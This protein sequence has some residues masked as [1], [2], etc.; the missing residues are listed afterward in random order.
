MNPLVQHLG[1]MLI[2]SVWEDGLIWCLLQ[3]ALLALARKSSQSRY[4]ASCLA[5][6]A[7]AVLPWLT[8]DAADISARL[9]ARPVVLAASGAIHPSLPEAVSALP[10]R[11]NQAFEQMPVPFVQSSDGAVPF[12]RWLPWL[13]ALWGAGVVLASL[14]LGVAW[15]RAR[16]LI[17]QPLPVLD[18]AWQERLGRLAQRAGVDRIVQL[19]ESAAVA[20]P[21]VAGWLKP[22][23]LLP[24]GVLT[25]L[26]VEQVEA[27][28]LHE[29][30]HIS[31]HDYLANLLQSIVESLFFYHPA[32]W[33][34]SRRIR[35][36]RELACDD[37]TVKWCQ[38]RHTYAE[39]LAGFEELRHQPPLLAATGE[40]DLLARIRRIL[41]E[42]SPARRGAPILG[43]AGLCG[44]G[45]YLAS[46]LLAPAI[47]QGALTA[48]ERITRIEALQPPAPLED[49]S[50][51]SESV[52]VAGTLNTEDGA[53]LPP[54]LIGGGSTL[55]QSEAVI[56]SWRVG[57]SS[58]GGIEI[59]P[60]ERTFYAVT[61]SG[62]IGIGIWAEGYAPLRHVGVD[63]KGKLALVLRR[64]FLARVQVVA[65]DG[66]L[67]PGAR[68][69]AVSSRAGEPFDLSMPPAHTDAAGGAS[70]GHVEAASEIHLTIT[71]P[72]WQM[73][74]RVVT[75]WEDQAPLV[76]RLEPAR[77]TAGQIIDAAS[78][79]PVAQA[80]IR[81]AAWR[82]E[83][84]GDHTYD[85][86][87]AQVL[88]HS[89]REGRFVLDGLAENSSCSIYIIAK[90]YATASFPIHYG[91]R[92]RIC[93]L[94]RG[95]RL[96]G[97]ILD[98]AGRLRKA[99]QPTQILCL[100]AISATPFFSYGQRQEQALASPGAE[101][102]FAF[103]DLPAG[104]IELILPGATGRRFELFLKKNVENYVIDLAAPVAP[105]KSPDTRPL[106]KVEITLRTPGGIAPAGA[107]EGTYIE[108][109][110]RGDYQVRKAVPLVDGKAAV[111]IPA[112]CQ[113]TLRA[114]R[115]IG[116]WFAPALIEVPAG[117]GT[118]TRTLDALPAGVIHGKVLLPPGLKSRYVTVTPVMLAAPAGM[119][120]DALAGA[121]GAALS[122]A[123]DY[124][125]PALPFGGTYAVLVNAAPAYFVGGPIGVDAGHPLAVVDMALP[126][127]QGALRGRLVDEENRPMVYR[128]VMLCYR[129]TEN[130]GF[131]SS[132]ATTDSEGR[133][134]IAG[135]NFALP[136]YYEVQVVDG[137]GW[138]SV[139]PRI[140]G[141]TE[142]PVTFS[143]RH[144]A[145]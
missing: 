29:L 94:A 23:I 19:G 74:E 25:A 106:R 67:L 122:A 26:P 84:E 3:V 85:P 113:L 5:L 6:A 129:P 24:L 41:G 65:S 61:M 22:V 102:P 44:I 46:M 132:S 123:G 115:L 81:L 49:A 54:S 108:K 13:V 92:D 138:T 91:D 57:G 130:R 12:A 96:R 33:A 68:I 93:A 86:A 125:T 145:N 109:G 45:L 71:K 134:V 63:G 90:G 121:S 77:P 39:A 128:E 111:E 143:L 56:C 36:E 32:M 79:L 43:L 117:A 118:F 72:G 75:H 80:E 73:A 136:G 100:Y 37:Q 35:R 27:I 17:G 139:A 144:S 9:A 142:Q 30:A 137:K 31:R 69:A 133:F 78:S 15:G 2:H 62:K 89:D 76:V 42:A 112:P 16:W 119:A 104:D 101:I 7:M 48:A 116:Y 59:D 107:V 126:E 110:E 47:A 124:V 1:W 4:L 103:D 52:A 40:G 10:V 34:V 98:P 20:I 38:D 120:A 64:G 141:R 97:K 105:P 131:I 18:S 14:R 127:P 88:G 50:A 87:N 95:M 11:M 99:Y 21:V 83:G 51:P 55:R 140:D 28:L 8:F 82:K 135:M 60:R 58:R 66:Q 114:D 70:F 53:P